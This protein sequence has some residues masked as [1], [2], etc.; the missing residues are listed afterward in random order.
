M[1]ANKFYIA[2]VIS[3]LFFSA[4]NAQEFKT[5]ESISDQLKK[6]TVPGTK[7]SSAIPAKKTQ[8]DTESKQKISVP[9]KKQ[10]LDGTYP[11]TVVAKTAVAVPAPAAQPG[12]ATLA[13]DNKPVAVEAPKP[14]PKPL[15]QE[16]KKEAIPAG[17][18]MPADGQ[19]E[20]QQ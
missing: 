17:K 4:A 6:G 11:G 18:V 19:K 3:L 1:K 10:L 13:S 8:N 5:N 20:K 16:E 7:V 12:S 2:T 9:V 15:M 14:A